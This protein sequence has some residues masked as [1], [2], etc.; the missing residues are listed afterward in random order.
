MISAAGTS[1]WGLLPAICMPKM[2]SE[3][4]RRTRDHSS[5]DACRK[6]IAKP[7][8]SGHLSLSNVLMRERRIEGRR[9]LATS[10]VCAVID[11]YTTKGLNPLRVRNLELIYAMTC[12]L[13][14][15]QQWSEVQGLR[16]KLSE[17]T[18]EGHHKKMYAQVLPVQ[19]NRFFS[20]NL[21]GTSGVSS[22]DLSAAAETSSAVASFV[23]VSK[24]EAA[25]GAPCASAFPSAF[26]PSLAFLIS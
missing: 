4:C 12:N 2:D 11:A 14:D 22:C 7:T 23:E 21:G 19:C 17:D 20:I 3:G 9:T 8:M 13:Q 16:V 25:V 10:D 26:S 15:S 24:L 6:D 5:F 18:G 1:S